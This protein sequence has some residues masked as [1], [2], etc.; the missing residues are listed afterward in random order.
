MSFTKYVV[1]SRGY[2]YNLVKEGKRGQGKWGKN[3]ILNIE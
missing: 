2:L 3:V 1:W